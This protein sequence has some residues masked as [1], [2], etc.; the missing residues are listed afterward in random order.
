MFF[1]IVP[2]MITFCNIKSSEV[3]SR[4]LIHIY[5]SYTTTQEVY[6]LS[7]W[8]IKLQKYIIFTPIKYT[9]ACSQDMVVFVQMDHNTDLRNF[10]VIND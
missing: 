6:P 5:M 1:E 2:N 10:E 4:H 8:Q 7:Y 9:S 3:I